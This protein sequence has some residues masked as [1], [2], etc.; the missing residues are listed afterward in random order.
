MTVAIQSGR[1]LLVFKITKPLVPLFFFPPKPINRP[2]HFTFH[3]ISHSSCA[4]PPGDHTRF[5]E[6]D[7]LRE[8]DGN[9][10]ESLTG[11]CSIRFPRR[12]CAIIT[13]CMSDFG[14][15]SRIFGIAGLFY[16]GL[17]MVRRTKKI[18]ISY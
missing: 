4:S 1:P 16:A 2:L 5:L 3:C 15:E 7:A 13:S 12:V 18:D 11:T 9:G 10:W 8:G 17:M 14:P 6:G